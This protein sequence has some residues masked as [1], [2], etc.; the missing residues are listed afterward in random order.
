[1]GLLVLIF[2][3][4]SNFPITPWSRAVAGSC[5]WKNWVWDCSLCPASVHLLLA[6]LFLEHRFVFYPLYSF[7]DCS[8]RLS[9]RTV[10]LSHLLQ[11]DSAPGMRAIVL[12]GGHLYRPQSLLQEEGY[13]LT[14]QVQGAD[15]SISTL[16]APT[17]STLDSLLHCRKGGGRVLAMGRGCLAW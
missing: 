11:P 5:E 15:L 10:S 4:L 1:M 2:W 16:A 13:E 3:S 7:M 14:W 9:W 12:G 6:P 8:P 17:P